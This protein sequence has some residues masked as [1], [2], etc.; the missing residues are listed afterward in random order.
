MTRKQALEHAVL[1]D[2]PIEVLQAALSQHPWDSPAELVMIGPGDIVR[3]L[4]RFVSGELSEEQVLSWAELIEC[5]EDIGYP[6]NAADAVKE[7]LF[8]LANPEI[9]LPGGVLTAETSRAVRNAL[10]V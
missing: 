5:R 10:R 3:I 8:L 2:M 1:L 9:N 6:E 4:D 7:A